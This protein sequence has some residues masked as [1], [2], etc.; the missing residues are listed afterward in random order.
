MALFLAS[1]FVRGDYTH[2]LAAEAPSYAEAAKYLD[3]AVVYETVDGA[4]NQKYAVVAPAPESEFAVGAGH[5]QLRLIET[6]SFGEG[7][8]AFVVSVCAP[9]AAENRSLSVFGVVRAD[10]PA[11][12]AAALGSCL[13]R[14]A[15]RSC[16]DSASYVAELGGAYDA[17]ADLAACEGDS[18]ANDADVRR[19][20]AALRLRAQFEILELRLTPVRAL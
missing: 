12:A 16:H 1:Y 6:V 17:L 3:A 14:G 13:R 8:R 7:A 9:H 18:P 15:E 4:T 10:S 5:R 2:V 11:E 19:Y 20:A